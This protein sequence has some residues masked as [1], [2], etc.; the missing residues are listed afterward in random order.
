MVGE[1]A[2]SARTARRCVDVD[3]AVGVGGDGDDAGGAEAEQAQGPVDRGVALLPG[4]DPD[5]G[6]PNRPSRSTSQPA[7][8]STRCR[9]DGQADVVRGLR[10]GD[11][12]HRGP[13]RK[14]QEILEPAAGRAFDGP[15]DGGTSAR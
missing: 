7:S 11:E 6:A 8:A 9:P 5:F 14:L 2:P 12:T 3:R 15:R 13:G 1:P 10:A 4:D